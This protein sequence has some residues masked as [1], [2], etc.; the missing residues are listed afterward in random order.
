MQILEYNLHKNETYL[1]NL[2]KII[3]FKSLTEKI[4]LIESVK[5]RHANHVIT[6]I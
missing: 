6:N 2:N 3:Y 4:L 1:K 5:A